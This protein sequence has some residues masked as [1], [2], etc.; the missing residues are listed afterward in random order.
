MSLIIARYFMYSLIALEVLLLPK[1]LPIEVYTEIEY[2]KFILYFM[3]F[4][5][6]GANSGFVYFKYNDD[7]DYFTSLL[8]IGTI[9]FTFISMGLYIYTDSLLFAISTLV[10]ALFMIVEQRVKTEKEF[11]LA[12]SIKPIISLALIILSTMYFYNIIST[13]SVS[14]LYY[15]IILAFTIWV[16]IVLYK[17]KDTIIVDKVVKIK[18]FFKLI[19]KGFLISVGTLLLMTLFFTD[20]YFT[21]E[22][23]PEYLASYSFS[24][25]LI[26][27]I[28]L[29]L[30]TIAYTN[31]VSIGESIK[32]IDIGFIKK[33]LLFAY[34]VFFILL[35]SFSIFIYVLSF[36]YDFISFVAISL[37]M[38]LFIG[39]FFTINSIGSIS[40]YKD[41][42]LN[43]TI[44]MFII[45]CLNV[46]I[47]YVMVEYGIEY[48]YLIIKTGILLSVYSFSFLLI[49]NSKYNR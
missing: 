23:Y 45:V 24:Y 13:V 29:A 3:P 32:S 11:M 34:K 6:F 49:V 5:L 19:Q 38:G 18:Y 47:S 28:V 30:A 31:T 22:F 15:S 48:I 1:I 39:N 33:Q 9:Y 12:M 27:F 7:E 41:F 20:R 2:Y 44:F 43:T 46:L 36:Y 21:K 25:N 35:I 14:F 17:L 10:I 37:I 8:A 26:Q 16:S 4:L 42:Q 40:Q